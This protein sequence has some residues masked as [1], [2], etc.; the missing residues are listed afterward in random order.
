MD[1]RFLAPSPES[2]CYSDWS[3]SSDDD[4]WPENEDWDSDDESIDYEDNLSGDG[5][6]EDDDARSYHRGE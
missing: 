5:E 6:N 2:G 1:S 4:H 3:V